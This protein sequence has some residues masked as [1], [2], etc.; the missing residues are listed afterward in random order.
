MRIHFYIISFLFGLLFAH[1]VLSGQQAATLNCLQVGENGEVTLLWTPVT[2]PTGFNNY[3]VYSSEDGANFTPI[4]T[5]PNISDDQFTYVD[6]KA[7]QQ[8]M[9]FYI[10]TSYQ[11]TDVQSE[12]LQTIFLQLDN[13]D[14]SEAQ[15]FW[16]F[17][18]EKVRGADPVTFNIWKEYP[19]GIWNFLTSVTDQTEY[20]ED[21]IVCED[22]INYRIEIENPA[23]CKSV[24]NTKGEWFK[25]LDEPAKPLIDSISINT[26]E[27]AVL[28]WQPVPNAGKYIVYRFEN[29][30]WN[31]IDTVIGV[32]NT[33]YEDSFSDPCTN[34]YTY[35]VATI[36]TCGISGPKDETEGRKSIRITDVSFDACNEITRLTWNN[37][38]NPIADSYEIWVSED[39]GPFEKIDE[40]QSQDTSYQHIIPNLGATYGY[41]IR[42]RF[43]GG[44]STTCKVVEKTYQYVLPEMIYFANADVLPS[45]F[46]ELKAIIDTVPQNCSWKIYREDSAANIV[47]V[48]SILRVDVTDTILS[49]I[50]TLVNPNEQSY[51][52][53]IEV[54]DSCGFEI[55]T[56][57]KLK[58]ILLGGT[59]IEENITILQWNA[60][61]GFDAGVEK[62]YIFRS[63]DGPEPTAPIDSVDALTFEYTDDISQLSGSS[64]SPIYW[65]QAYENEGNEYGARE[66]S[67]SNRLGVAQDGEMYVA[68]AFRPGGYTAEFKPVYRFYNGRSY[69]FQIYNRWGQLIFETQ[70]PEEGWDGKY[71]GENVVTGV[72]VYRL[73]YQKNDDSSVEKKGTVTVIY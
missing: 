73:V 37:Y 55:L 43:Q 47:L 56:S 54:L 44:T 10:E 23:R 67:N 14:F 69:L 17:E 27:N 65:V 32:D 13:L 66:K 51:T 64:G 18:K 49:Y 42:A 63:F 58:T 41:F 60:F 24:S 12:E 31:S 16:N 4:E 71:N 21:V 61:E 48:D 46:I 30:I 53:W 40:T 33:F 50:D 9:W 5:I 34:N 68:N 20:K 36:D 35:T 28:G 22:S 52:Y 3:V 57:N 25:I 39:G 19:L 15:L 72:Y 70:N 8:S 62:Y 26:S 11:S 29:G 45:N 2:D 6:A 1:Q 59:S 38:K 7:N